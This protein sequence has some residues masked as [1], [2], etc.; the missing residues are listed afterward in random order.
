MVRIEGPKGKRELPLEKFFVIP[1]TESEREHDLQ[2][3]EIMTE[4]VVPAGN[5]REGC[6]L[7]NP[8]E[9]G[10]RL[11]TRARRRRAE[12]EWLQ[13][14]NRPGCAGIRRARPV[15]FTGSRASHSRAQPVNEESAQKAA[16]AALQAAKPLSQNGYKVQLA[17][18][19]VKRAILKAHTEVPHDRKRSRSL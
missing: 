16:D 18:V 17:R 9:G 3:N 14:T 10:L 8:P 11:A 13:G 4:V 5:G 2:P 7:R 1:R 6:A 12:D 15:A 19:A